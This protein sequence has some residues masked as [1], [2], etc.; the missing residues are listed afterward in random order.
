MLCKHLAENYGADC[1]GAFEN[2]YCFRARSILEVKSYLL[3]AGFN[4]SKEQVQWGRERCKNLKQGSVDLRLQDYRD[5]NEKFDRMVV[6][7]MLEH[8][9]LHNYDEFFS[10]KQFLL[11]LS[12]LL[13]TLD[14][15]VFN[16]AM[17]LD[18]KTLA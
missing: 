13:T 14:A 5:V 6:A 1:V 18:C 4:I 3:F 9:G 7:G 16:M 10:V 17:S 11:F 2:K 8:V 15:D 12:L